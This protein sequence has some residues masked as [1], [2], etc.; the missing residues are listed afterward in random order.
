V[1]SIDECFLQFN[2]YQIMNDWHQYGH[3]IRQTVW[4]ET[5]L[6]VGVGFGVTPTLAIAASLA[7]KKL[8]TREEMVWHVVLALTNNCLQKGKNLVMT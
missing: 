4:R 8:S 2:G 5:K 7:A 1:Y 3:F 6:P